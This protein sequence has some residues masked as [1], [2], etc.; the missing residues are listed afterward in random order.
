MPV[1]RNDEQFEPFAALLAYLVP[2][3]GH[4]ALGQKARA[5][6]IFVGVMG[7]FFGGLFIGGID[8]VDR[9]EDFWWF[10]GQAGAGPVAFAVDR[11][12]QSWFKVA[13]PNTPGGLRT[14]LP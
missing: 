8:S 12:H 3:L 4:L 9:K 6:W 11:V 7:L 13:D 2:G 5:A 1:S 14:P 10:V